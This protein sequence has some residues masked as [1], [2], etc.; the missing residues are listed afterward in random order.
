V[1]GGA[2]PHPWAGAAEG[3]AGFPIFFGLVFLRVARKHSRRI[4]RV[5][6]DRPC[7]FSFFDLKAYAVMAFMITLGVSVR[8][9]GLVPPDI[10]G[11]FY[12][13]LGLSLA[14]AAVV[15]AWGG[16]R[17]ANLREEVVKGR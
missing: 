9:L 14:G 3:A 4:A 13:S 11:P 17:W 15:F 10:L 1:G 8:V 7:A 2:T 16:L 6:D 5:T 12:V